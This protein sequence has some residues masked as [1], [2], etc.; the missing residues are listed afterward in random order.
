M[1]HQITKV[2]LTAAIVLF[3]VIGV[4][5]ATITNSVS[6]AQADPPTRHHCGDLP[7]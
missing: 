3:A 7:N 5:L 6:N 4:A 2:G 1:R